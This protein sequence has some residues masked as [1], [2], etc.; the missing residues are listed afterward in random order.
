MDEILAE[1]RTVKALLQSVL[2]NHSRPKAVP[3]KVAAQMMGFGVTKLDRLIREGVIATVDGDPYL[4]PVSE[5]DRY[6]A[7]KPN[8]QR[9]ARTVRRTHKKLL[10]EQSDAAWEALRMRIREKARR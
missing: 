1:L 7:P 10:D 5:I 2:E 9:L 4:V 6:C 3:R 8:R